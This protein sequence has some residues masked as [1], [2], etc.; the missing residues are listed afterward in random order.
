MF[1][2]PGGG[3]SLD[4]IEAGAEQRMEFVLARTE[5]AAAVDFA[6]VACAFG[7]QAERV[8]AKDALPSP[9]PGVRR[10]ATVSPRRPGRPARLSGA[11]QGAARM[12]AVRAES[13]R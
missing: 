4:L 5:T 3:S 2:V 6:A 8:E 7:L 10:R 9:R 11:P 1:G 13:W 12:T